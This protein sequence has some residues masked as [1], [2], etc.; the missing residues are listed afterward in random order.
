MKF[1]IKTIDAKQDIELWGDEAD[2]DQ[3]SEIKELDGHLALCV[4]GFEETDTDVAEMPS[5]MLT[6]IVTQSPRYAHAESH[7]E[8][9]ARAFGAL[10]EDVYWHRM[11][12]QDRN[13]DAL[14]HEIDIRTPEAAAHTIALIKGW[15]VE[16]LEAEWQVSAN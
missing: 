13:G 14:V 5:S 9:M 12:Q 6:A 16:M 1:V 8:M 4:L 11:I 7:H 2:D 15:L 10:G 3:V